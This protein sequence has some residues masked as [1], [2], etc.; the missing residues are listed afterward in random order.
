[1]ENNNFIVFDTET[2]SL[3]KPFVY[4]IGYIIANGSEI[5]VKRDYVVEQIWHNLPLFNSAYYADKRPLYVER[6]RARTAVL[7]KFGYICQQMIRDFKQYEIKRAFAYNSAFDDRVFTF[8]CDWFKVINP[9]DNVEIVDI[10]GFV[11]QFLIGND[12]QAFCE[13]YEYF[14]DNGN[15]S[16]TAETV[17]RYLENDTEIIEEHTALA[18]SILEYNILMACAK[19]GADIMNTA[20]KAKISVPRI[21]EK[22]LH[23]KTAEQTEYFFKYHK[24][25]I[26]KDKTE[27]TLK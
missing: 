5:L 17:I 19:Y 7:E 6:M 9:F 25:R 18:D 22:E 27:I 26:S 8:N 1:M 20:P 10:R 2:T 12:F 15:Y 21:I 11:H 14:T 13:K 24:I 4:N 16:T 23:I 3:D